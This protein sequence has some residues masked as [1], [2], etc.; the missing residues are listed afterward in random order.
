MNIVVVVQSMPI[1]ENYL[2]APHFVFSTEL[3]KDDITVAITCAKRVV[4]D[5]NGISAW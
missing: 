3:L 2:S 5:P 4:R 1:F